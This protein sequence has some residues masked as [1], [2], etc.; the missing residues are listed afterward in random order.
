MARSRF[1]RPLSALAL[2]A[3]FVAGPTGEVSAVTPQDSGALPQN[4]NLTPEQ[5]F[6]R[7]YPQPVKVGFLTASSA[8]SISWT[9][10][11]V[12]TDTFRVHVLSDRFNAGGVCAP[13]A[14]T[15]T[16]PPVSTLPTA[17]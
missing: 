17:T 13:M 6:A 15:V 5:K 8:Y 7:R 1:V 3:L 9:L 11:D 16:Q 14:I 12:G 4:Q 2:A 10:G